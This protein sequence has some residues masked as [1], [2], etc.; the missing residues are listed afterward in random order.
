MKKREI[1]VKSYDRFHYGK[2][3]HIKA[4]TRE[5]PINEA[6]LKKLELDKAR[7]LNIDR[8]VK[9]H[10]DYLQYA[11]LTFLLPNE[12]WKKHPDICDV[13]GLDCKDAPEWKGKKKPEHGIPGQVVKYKGE[14]YV[15]DGKGRFSTTQKKI[16]EYKPEKVKKKTPQDPGPKKARPSSQKEIEQIKVPKV[17]ESHKELAEQL[18]P[19]EIPKNKPNM[20]KYNELMKE[21][22]EIKFFRGQ[23]MEGVNLS[24]SARKSRLEREAQKYHHHKFKVHYDYGYTADARKKLTRIVECEECG[25]SI[26]HGSAERLSESAIWR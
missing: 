15:A 2:L 25:M 8:L 11:R 19:L 12:Y 1:P 9:T 3:E 16:T 24:Q 23:E 20:K 6:Y 7:E 26:H 14:L 10:P 17:K 4:T 13:L 22:S 18:P 5:V 21:A